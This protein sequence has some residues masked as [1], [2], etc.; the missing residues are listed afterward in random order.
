MI[1]GIYYPVTCMSSIFNLEHE[2]QFLSAI[3]RNPLILADCPH[4]NEK[5]FSPINRVIY[6]VLQNS[7]LDSSKEF[8]K[9]ILI[10]KLKTLNIKIGDAIEPDIYINALEL[11][12]VND[13]AA[14]SI[15]KE[16]KRTTVRRVLNETAKEMLRLTE[17]DMQKKSVELVEELTSIFNGKVNLLG[18]TTEGEPEDLYG[19]INQFLDHSDSSY[20]TRSVATPYAIYNDMYGITD[21]G[22]LYVIAA[23]AKVGKSTWV[24]SMLQ[25][26]AIAD[27]NKNE[28][29]GLIL[30]T[31]L[32]KEE[33]Q[34]RI[35]SSITGIKEFYIRHKIYRRHSDMN[36]KVEQA[37]EIIRPLFNKVDHIFIGG[38]SLDAQLSIVRRWVAKKVRGNK[39]CIVVFDYF[40]LNSNSDF[41]SNTS[42]DIIIGKKVN[43]YKDLSK[44]LKIPVWA[45]VQANRENE[46]SKAGMRIS[47]GNA[48]AG[49]DMISQFC[50][51]I[52]LLQ[53]LNVDEKMEL[54]QIDPDSATHNLVPIYT[55][56]LGPDEMGQHKLVK[57]QD[58]HTGKD[59]YRENSIYYN[60][61]N[62][63]VTEVGTFK[64]IIER[65]R[66]LGINVQPAAPVVATAANPVPLKML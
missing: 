13:L 42:R 62:F 37:R 24:M 7:I 46:D 14:I 1:E 50:T 54:N 16:I 41:D 3:I 20:D 30:D 65:N 59:R 5:D 31:E 58:H 66:V 57:F 43:A 8:N 39:R 55:R 11:I 48:V 33:V 52:Y 61:S 25:Q 32:T 35:I 47:N 60:F 36:A 64:D 34:C 17:K 44:E 23:R 40:K 28:F 49:S 56:Q 15:A 38:K 2:K 18:G 29:V 45:L 12:G 4:I 51:N 6:Q 21:P 19:T 27:A 63:K 9:F 22:N 10:E 53:K 26:I